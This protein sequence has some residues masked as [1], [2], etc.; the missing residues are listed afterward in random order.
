MSPSFENG[1]RP[2]HGSEM[3]LIP[4]TGV[5]PSLLV[6]GSLAFD[7]LERD[8]LVEHRLGGVVTYGGLTAARLG[9]HVDIW[10]AMPSGAV[11]AVRQ[12]LS[13]LH[14]MPSESTEATRFVN[15]EYVGGERQQLCPTRARSLHWSDR[16]FAADAQ[17]DWIHL[18][19]LHPD[20]ISAEV[21]HALR[22]R[23][24][25]MSLDL[26]GLTR[27]VEANGAVRA[28][29]AEQ[30]RDVLPGLDWVKA[31]DAEWAQVADHLGLTAG[32]A[33]ARF[34]WRGL[35]VSAGARGGV[36]HTPTGALPWLAEVPPHVVLETGAGDV[37]TTSFVGRLLQ[38]GEDVAAA[39]SFAAYVAGRHVAGEWLDL[40]G[41]QIPPLADPRE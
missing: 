27:S 29:V 26:Q 34:G 8:G 4:L 22:P 40:T 38:T 31:S 37:F 13:G 30:V 32:L 41:L 15:R 16:P 7:R 1:D 5:S 9:C 23:C 20:D 36:L 17:W 25:V 10:S 19:P 12:R 28:E 39:M 6:V 2:R 11:D 14:V 24:R 21:V 18:G 33:V 35:L 3:G